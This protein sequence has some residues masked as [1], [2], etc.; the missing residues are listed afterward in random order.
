VLVC[1][2]MKQRAVGATDLNEH[3][4]RSHAI[5]CMEVESQA[6]LNQD[7]PSAKVSKTKRLGRLFVVDLAGS[8]RLSLSG[9]W[10]DDTRMTETQNINLSLTVL[11][12]VLSTLAEPA[13]GPVVVPYRNSKLTFLL[14]DSLGGSAR[15]IM[16]VHVRPTAP[17]YRQT[18]VTMQ[19]A[20]RARSVRNQVSAHIEGGTGDSAADALREREMEELRIRVET[21]TMEAE[22]ARQA[23][24][25]T[26]EENAQLRARLEEL[27]AELGTAESRLRME[28]AQLE[29]Q[30]TLKKATPVRSSAA[31]MTSPSLLQS[32]TE[33]RSAAKEVGRLR[34]ELA[35]ARADMV[36]LTNRM[37]IERRTAADREDAAVM[38]ARQ[39]AE[40]HA[41]ARVSQLE[42]ELSRAREE[43]SRMDDEYVMELRHKLSEAEKYAD[44]STFHRLKE[45]VDSAR[46]L[47]QDL[48]S[49]RDAL[50]ESEER[51]AEEEARAAEAEEAIESL[52]QQIQQVEARAAEQSKRFF[53]IA[54]LE[55]S[56]AAVQLSEARELER[57][58]S[59]KMVYREAMSIAARLQILLLEKTRRVADARGRYLAKFAAALVAETV[60]AE[61]RAATGLQEKE[62]E[63]ENLREQMLQEVDDAKDALLQAERQE[64]KR[65]EAVRKEERTLAEAKIAAAVAEARRVAHAQGIDQAFGTLQANSMIVPVTARPQKRGRSATPGGT[66]VPDAVPV[67][68]SS[69]SEGGPAASD[70][71]FHP[72]SSEEE[73]SFEQSPKRT[74]PAK[75]AK[76]AAS[77][78]GDDEEASEPV[79][80]R[81]AS[82]KKQSDARKSTPRKRAPKSKKPPSEPPQADAEKEV[83][84]SQPTTPREVAPILM[85]TPRTRSAMKKMKQVATLVEEAPPAAAVEEKEEEEQPKPTKRAS[86]KKLASQSTLLGPPANENDSEPSGRAAALLKPIRTAA[87]TLGAAKKA[88]ITIG[89][90]GGKA[91][92][93]PKL[94]TRL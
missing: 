78:Q 74:R 44:P 52:E 27:E 33:T 9:A 3:S 65:V 38:S 85:P 88:G 31:V 14:R 82:K 11:A 79:E 70:D 18:L 23:V 89:G 90:V 10:K 19:Y 24:S 13:S 58:A 46:V 28:L 59:A 71:S 22:A 72:A 8:E 63:L 60:G 73:N 48:A 2:G 5:V 39:E 32:M 86:K 35:E 17:H 93:A 54:A 56:M 91:F 20:Q 6:R 62:E 26:V 41:A 57:Q 53:A 61:R 76:Q 92:T 45:A 37:E 36:S 55:R 83:E 40:D 87:S 7:D 16:L 80:P 67:V 34:E 12:D 49:V 68:A 64:H 81:R 1:R 66:T 51:C 94:K 4:S 43:A 84:V 42:E 30:L 25:A 47:R 15:T 77:A 21:R 75:R 50:A 29:E 69:S